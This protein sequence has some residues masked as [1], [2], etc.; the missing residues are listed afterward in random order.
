MTFSITILGSSGTYAGPD[1]ACSGYLLR[2]DGYSLLL[3]CGPGTLAALQQHVPLDTLDAIVVSHSHP[4]HWLEIPVMRNA[5]RYVLH[6]SDI[7]LCS[8]EETLQL[9]ELMSHNELT[10]TFEPHVVTDGDEQTLGPFSLRFARTDHPPETMSVRADVNDFSFA[11]SADTGPAWSFDQ[12]GAD[13]DL[14]VCEATVLEDDKARVAGHHLSAHEAGSI[15]RDAG[16]GRLVITHLMPGSVAADHAA[17]AA[18]AYGA[19]VMVAQPGV[20]FD[21]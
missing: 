8:T 11:Y 2:A 7:P 3:D 13:I 9:A 19:P 4:D 12:L 21:E 1:N 15:A 16:V 14:A 17:E 5:L 18:A 20:V 10:P 6:R